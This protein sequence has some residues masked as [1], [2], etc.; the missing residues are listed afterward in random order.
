MRTAALARDPNRFLSAVQIGVTVAGFLSAAYG[1]STIAPALAPTL[2][3]WG[4]PTVPASAIAL[5]GTTLTIA[6]LSLILGELVPKRIALQRA[7]GV[8]LLTAPALDR[9]A[10]VMRPVIWLL[11][12]STDLLVRILGGDPK[13]TNEAITHEELRDLVIGHTATAENERRIHSEV[14]DAGQRSLSEVMRPRTD[15]R[16]LSADTPVA[17]AGR[18][19]LEWGHSRYPVIGSSFDDIVGFVHLHDRAD[20]SEADVCR[21][22]LQ[23]PASKPALAALADMRQNNR[24]LTIVVDEYGGTAGIATLED[25]VEEIV[26]EIGDEYDNPTAAEPSPMPPHLTVDGLLIV[27]D[28]EGATGIALPDGPYETVAGFL[29]HRLQRVPQLGDSITFDGHILTVSALDGRRISRIRVT[30]R[31]SDPRR[32]ATGRAALDHN[33]G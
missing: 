14:F 22:V 2:E 4:M 33:Q 15:V 25:I 17:Q 11:S 13:T 28:F 3:S 26:G 32:P 27:E 8:A 16:F 6:Y 24:Q 5:V 31:A 19:A 29:L 18:Q 7:A 23:L 12:A 9:F 10:S 21:P 20:Q 1:A 30:H